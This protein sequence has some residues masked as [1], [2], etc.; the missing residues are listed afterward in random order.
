VVDDAS[1]DET[2][3]LA[4][5]AGATVIKRASNGGAAAARNAGVRHTPPWGLATNRIMGYR[6]LPKTQLKIPIRAA[7]SLKLLFAYALMRDCGLSCCTIRGVSGIRN[8]S[9]DLLSPALRWSES[10]ANPNR[11]TPTE[12]NAGCRAF[13]APNPPSPVRIH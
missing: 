11:A 5:A 6:T 9:T 4:K 8:C 7:R 2:V 13:V 10:K 3:R 1:T 12:K